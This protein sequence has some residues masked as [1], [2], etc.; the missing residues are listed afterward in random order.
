M[1]ISQRIKVSGLKVTGPRIK[2]LQLLMDGEKR[3]WRAE[4]LF[5]TLRA[6]G[7][8]IGL[9]TVYRILTQ[10]EKVGLIHKHRFEEEHA[11]FEFA[12]LL[13][14]DHLVCIQCGKVEEF[15]D[16]VI[17]AR[18]RVIAENA[19]FILTS[20]ALNLFGICVGCRLE[21]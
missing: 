11:V 1:D 15:I 4:E 20:H 6:D 14:H 19:Q 7:V 13:H 8:E 18:Q 17:E 10:F 21:A 9:A 2:M 5:Q 3:H 12:E 16:P